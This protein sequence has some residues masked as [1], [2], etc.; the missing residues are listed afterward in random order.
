[1]KTENT[2]RCLT[3]KEAAIYLGVSTS[4]LRISRCHGAKAGRFPPPP[5]VRLGRSIRYLKDDLDLWLEARRV[6]LGKLPGWQDTFT[7]S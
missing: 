1:M 2:K 6:V 4:T 3:D 5:F 7:E